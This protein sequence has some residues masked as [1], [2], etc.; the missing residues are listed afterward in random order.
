MLALEKV[1]K[2]TRV[3]EKAGL[4]SAN[5]NQYVFEVYPSANRLEVSHAVAKKFNVT[6]EGVNILNRAGKR[7]RSRTARGK[8][9]RRVNRKFAIVTLKSGDK[10]EIV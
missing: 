9:D 5:S 6:V 4:L 1:L 8:L 7:K 10:I 3:T 2:A